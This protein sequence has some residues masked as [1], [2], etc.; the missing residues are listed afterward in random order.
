MTNVETALE[1]Y[2]ERQKTFDEYR[3][4]EPVPVE[5]E[6]VSDVDDEGDDDENVP[7]FGGD[8]QVE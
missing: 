2:N 5:L 3:G 1:I 4:Q 8:L 7:Q 6:E